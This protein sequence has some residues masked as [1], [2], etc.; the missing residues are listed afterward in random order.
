MKWHSL[1]KLM[2]KKVQVNINRNSNII[3]L[4]LSSNNHDNFLLKAS[5][6]NTKMMSRYFLL[7]SLQFLDINLQIA[8]VVVL[9]LKQRNRCAFVNFVDVLIVKIVLK[10]QDFFTTSS[11]M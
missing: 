10:K 5:S 1:Q 4:R 3:M 8:L 2:N 6:T 11:K 9:N 7:Q